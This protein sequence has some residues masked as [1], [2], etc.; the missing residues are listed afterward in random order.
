MAKIFEEKEEEV[1]SKGWNDLMRYAGNLRSAERSGTL[2]Q[3]GFLKEQG[4]NEEDSNYLLFINKKLGP[5]IDNEVAYVPKHN[6][7]TNPEENK[8][9]TKVIDA[10]KNQISSL[11]MSIFFDPGRE[12][13]LYDIVEFVIQFSYLFENKKANM[14]NNIPMKLLAQF[15][16][17]YL[18]S[19]P[20]SYIT[21]NF[22][23]LY[24]ALIKDYEERFEFK[25]RLANR[26]K[27]LLLLAVNFM[28]KHIGDIKQ[29]IR[30]FE[31]VKR[32]E[33]FLKFIK[34]GKVPVCLLSIRNGNNLTIQVFPQSTCPHSK[35]ASV[36]EFVMGS[37]KTSKGSHG[38]EATH[39]SNIEEFYQKFMKLDQV[40]QST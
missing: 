5:G 32:K 8:L 17:A 33:F 3:S 2:I 28:E 21:H 4:L 10:A 19:I 16:A 14:Q 11:D 40:V 12:W 7:S 39:V 1:R 18:K 13:S 15:L 34:K 36:N 29:E 27:K 30:V 23:K 25:R 24:T 26:N 22:R 35:L 37:K 38:N 9:L 6:F 20:Q 31:S